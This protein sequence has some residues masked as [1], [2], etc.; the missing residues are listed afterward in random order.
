MSV[1]PFIRFR[2]NVAC[3][4]RHTAKIRR[5]DMWRK[6]WLALRKSHSSGKEKRENQANGI[7]GEK[8]AAGDVT[9]KATYSKNL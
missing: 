8:K 9:A 6:Q 2:S 4:K 7:Q 3:S 1:G 5:S